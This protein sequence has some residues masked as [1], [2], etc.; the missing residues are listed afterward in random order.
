MRCRGNLMAGMV[1]AV[2]I[3]ILL[4]R[5]IPCKLVIQNIYPRIAIPMTASTSCIRTIDGWSITPGWPNFRQVLS[6]MHGNVWA[7]LL[8]DWLISFVRSMLPPLTGITIFCLLELLSLL[9]RIIVWNICGSSSSSACS[10]R[11]CLL[12]WLLV[13]PLIGWMNMDV[14]TARIA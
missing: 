8:S 2:S 13:S 3:W 9:L 10:N 14:H 11:S 5:L 6:C 7:M 1:I 12:L 4:P